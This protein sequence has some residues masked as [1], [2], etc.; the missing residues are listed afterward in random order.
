[1]ATAQ[2]NSLS[3]GTHTIYVNGE[4]AAGNWSGLASTTFVVQTATDYWTGQSASTGGN[5]NWSNAGNWSMNADPGAGDIAEFISSYS[6]DGTAIMDIATTVAGLDIDSTWGGTLTVSNALSINGNLTLA[7]GTINGNGTISAAGSGSEWS[8]GSLAGAL[9]NAGTLT[10]SGSSGLSLSGTLTNNGTILDTGPGTISCAT[11]TQINNE[12]GATFNFQA[13]ASL[14]NSNGATG[15]SFTNAG[16][17]E[18]SAG[19]G[20]SLIS[21]FVSN[22]GTIAGDSGTLQLTGGG[23]GMA[24]TPSM[25]RAEWF[26]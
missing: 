14:E 7:S 18:K 26:S 15:T 10:I 8:A 22:T 21:V 5:D 16:I 2:F 9:T 6:K 25:R 17:L 19:S 13:D 24:S 12:Q 4:D 3:L 20:N 11:G 1:M 23:S